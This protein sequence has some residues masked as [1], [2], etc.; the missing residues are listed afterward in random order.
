MI[1]LDGLLVV[2][3]AL[4]GRQDLPIPEWLFAWG[5]SLVLIV[6]FVALSLA[7][8][9]TRFED[10]T[11]RPVSAGSRLVVNPATEVLAGALGVF[12]LV[13]VVWSGLN[14]TEAPDRNF[15]LT[16]VFV[17]FWLG[18]VVLS[19][20]SATCSG[21]SIPG[22][23]SPGSSGAGSGSWPDSR[24]APPLRLPER[25]GRWPAAAGILAFVWL[26][27]VY[28][29]A[30]FQTVGLSPHGRDRHPRVLRLRSS[31]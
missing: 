26:E 12:L 24:R 2:G 31:A 19:V 9:R 7:W 6:S 27:L 4:V 15:S 20:G 5:A 13:V 8:H 3:H 14:G 23:R 18:L 17:T 22:G 16:F 28:G 25:F 30:G 1:N 21:P 11:W 29:A 10:D